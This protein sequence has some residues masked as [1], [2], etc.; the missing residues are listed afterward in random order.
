MQNS[1][2]NLHL[3]TDS[4]PY[5]IKS[6]SFLE[7][8]IL[9]LAKNFEKV[10]IYPSNKSSGLRNLPINVIVLDYLQDF[11]RA[12]KSTK[13]L[14]IFCNLF[15]V[16]KT[17]FTEL[18]EKRSSIKNMSFLLKNFALQIN[19]YRLLNKRKIFNKSDLYYDYWLIN[20]GLALC[21]AKNRKVIEK[22]ICRAHGYDLYDSRWP[23][24]AVPFKYTIS[25]YVDKIYLISKEGRRHI[26]EKFR[27]KSEIAKLGVKAGDK[28]GQVNK[29]DQKTIVSCSNVIEIKRVE[30]IAEFLK[31]VKA[32]IIWYHFGNGILFE[33]LKIKCNE[34]PEN[35]TVKLLGEI[36]NSEILNFYKKKQVDLFI[37]T[38]STEGIPVSM[39]EAISYGIQLTAYPVGGIPEILIP[40]KTGTFLE[41][42]R[43]AEIIEKLLKNRIE[44]Q[45]ILDF[46]EKNFS[47]SVNY[48]NFILLINKLY[49]S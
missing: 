26:P 4:F 38:S 6:E 19:K 42:G 36:P 30:L 39:M 43:E 37:S 27:L 47:S 12:K 23:K 21:L 32:N 31:E 35:I 34:L 11:D 13:L 20:A 10:Y 28:E 2:N 7:T 16:I 25:K 8:E 46:Y 41:K 15:F 18:R 40:N 33:E 24:Q 17:L 9:F 44:P 22:Y 48:G 14:L 5:G 1:R 3:F 45:K 49:L 29:T